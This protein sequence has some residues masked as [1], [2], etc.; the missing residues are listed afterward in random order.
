MKYIT[1]WTVAFL[2]LFLLIFLRVQDN[3]LVE[4]AR[5]K[6][7]DYLQSTDSITQSQGIVVV[8]VDEAAIEANGQ[9]PW[10][11]DQIADLIWQLR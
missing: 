10:S 8:E 6:S 9:W 4:T 5:L 3:G 1:H 2:T 11:R 7:F